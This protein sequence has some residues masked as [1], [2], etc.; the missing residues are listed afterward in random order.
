MVGS[1]TRV[2]FVNHYLPCLCYQTLLTLYFF[3][4]LF[5]QSFIPSVVALSFVRTWILLRNFAW[6]RQRSLPSLVVS[7]VAVVLSITFLLVKLVVTT[8]YRIDGEGDTDENNTMLLLLLVSIFMVCL[9]MIVWNYRRRRP[10]PPRFGR[11]R[12]RFGWL[13]FVR[14]TDDDED[15]DNDANDEFDDDKEDVSSAGGRRHGDVT[16][17]TAPTLNVI[18]LLNDTANYTSYRGTGDAATVAHIHHVSIPGTAPAAAAASFRRDFGDG[19]IMLL[20][21]WPNNV[22]S[23]WAPTISHL[24]S[25]TG[26]RLIAFDSVTGIGASTVSSAA[27]RQ[28]GSTHAA[29]WLNRSSVSLTQKFCGGG[30][31]GEH[32]CED[33]DGHR[34]GDGGGY[35]GGGGGGVDGKNAKRRGASVECWFDHTYS[36]SFDDAAPLL[37]DLQPGGVTDSHAAVNGAVINVAGGGGGGFSGG[38][39]S[40]GGVGGVGGGGAPE[41]RPLVALPPPLS[42]SPPPLPRTVDT[43]ADVT[44]ALFSAHVAVDL[45]RAGDGDDAIATD[46]VFASAST[47]APSAALSSHSSLTSI[48]TSMLPLPLVAPRQRRQ[49]AIIAH[50]RGCQVALRTYL[51]DPSAVKALVLVA[52]TFVCS[53]V[54]DLV[55]AVASWSSPAASTALLKA[56][57]TMTTTDRVRLLVSSLCADDVL[58]A[59]ASLAPPPRVPPPPRSTTSA[60]APSTLTTTATTTAT[61]R[62]H[63]RRSYEWRAEFISMQ[64]QAWFAS[65]PLPPLS[66]S[67]AARLRDDAERRWLRTV[68]AVAA[69]DAAERDGSETRRILVEFAAARQRHRM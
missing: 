47:S 45:L 37:P 13:T 62:Q 33:D 66:P 16:K 68:A 46:V 65:P 21:G 26:A 20:P 58:F 18:A 55:R 43:D 42:A 38:F 44:S 63:S 1:I 23:L 11:S 60:P 19:D 53:E 67:A 12:Q 8:S 41:R 7:S 34:G 39:G 22:H 3:L 17:K 50:G 59:G 40:G 69:S 64:L 25:T 49:H 56:T 51:L 10:V 2:A 54:S 15:E 6:S 29:A 5:L 32:D 30:C 57:E 9:E 28:R 31:G 61:T 14:A 27:E 35:S 24:S 36:A 48:H 52:P 4:P